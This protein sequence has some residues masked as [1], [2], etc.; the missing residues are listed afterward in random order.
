MDKSC[1]ALNYLIQ[2]QV[3]ETRTYPSN[4]EP[5]QKSG[6]PRTVCSRK[7]KGQGETGV[8]C[9]DFWPCVNLGLKSALLASAMMYMNHFPL[10]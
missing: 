10:A 3:K 2:M 1:S 9:H 8:D 4:T 6:W 5:L 7:S